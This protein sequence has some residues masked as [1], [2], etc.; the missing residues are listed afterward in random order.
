MASAPRPPIVPF[1]AVKPH[2]LRCFFHLRGSRMLAACQPRRATLTSTSFRYTANR[3]RPWI[4]M[5][6]PCVRV[7]TRR[8]CAGYWLISVPHQNSL[9]TSTVATGD[10]NTTAPRWTAESCCKSSMHPIMS[11]TPSRQG[12][13]MARRAVVDMGA[14]LCLNQNL[15]PDPAS[16]TG[17][18]HG[19]R[20]ATAFDA[21]SL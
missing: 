21:Q 4:T 16:Y 5:L 8:R 1:A 11:K 9:P 14:D 2:R 6:G 3:C 10:R 12:Q 15:L 19:C 17:F 18:W 7:Q 20:T 13:Y